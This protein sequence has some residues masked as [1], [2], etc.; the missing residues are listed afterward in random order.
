MPVKHDIDI[1]A[2][3]LVTSWEG[4]AIDT[5]FIEALKNYQKN[6]QSD[7]AH[8]GFNEIVDLTKMTKIKITLQGL[9]NISSIA[10][11]TDNNNIRSK[12][13]FIVSSKRAFS[14]VKL[15]SAYRSLGKKSSKEINVFTNEK[16]AFEWVSQ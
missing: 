4:V 3:L 13:A 6:I 7:S 9:K 15:Y 12:L 16:D 11:L 1:D 14:L 8:L 10:L 5:E 2:K